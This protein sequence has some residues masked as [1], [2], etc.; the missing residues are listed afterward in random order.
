MAATLDQALW[1]DELWSEAKSDAD[2]ENLS[3]YDD[4]ADRTSA[5]QKLSVL[6]RVSDRL[7]HDFGTWRVP[8]GEINRCQ[9]L[10]GDI[11]QKFNDAAPSIPV[12][13]TSARWAALRPLSA[14]GATRTS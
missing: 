8:W 4:M 1:G 12:E 3:V 6:A 9:R 14:L 10:T 7:E 11:V 13:F 5:E 2:A